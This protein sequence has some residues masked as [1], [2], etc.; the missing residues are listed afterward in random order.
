MLLSATHPGRV[1]AYLPVFGVDM[2]APNIVAGDAGESPMAGRESR[3][4]GIDEAM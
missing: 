1:N 4:H 3:R 2:M